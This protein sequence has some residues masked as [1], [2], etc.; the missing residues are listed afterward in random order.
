[1]F[2]AIDRVSKFTCV[3]FHERANTTTGPAFLRS[4]VAAFPYRIRIVL[5]DNGIPS[6]TCRRTAP[7]RQLAFAAICSTASAANTASSIGS[8]SPTILGPTVR[9]NG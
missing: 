9:L 2:L 8:P 3:E 5:T 4:V 7:A 6:R 1:M